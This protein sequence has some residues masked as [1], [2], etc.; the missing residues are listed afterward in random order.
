MEG[1]VY[2]NIYNIDIYLSVY[3]SL[4]YLLTITS[5]YNRFFTIFTKGFEKISISWVQRFHIFLIAFFRYR[6]SVFSS[7]MSKLGHKIRIFMVI[8]ITII[9]TITITI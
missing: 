4:H 1:G 3:L 6:S 5:K 9:T 7:Y 2:K 8:T